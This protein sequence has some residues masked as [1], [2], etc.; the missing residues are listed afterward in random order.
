M[1]FEGLMATNLQQLNW[2]SVCLESIMLLGKPAEAKFT[3]REVFK[4][5]QTADLKLSPKE[6]RMLQHDIKYLGHIISPKGV[7]TSVKK[8]EA[9]HNWSAP[10]DV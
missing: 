6:W 5:L 8:T 9:I 1:T 4:R 10:K 3:M 2:K 7:R